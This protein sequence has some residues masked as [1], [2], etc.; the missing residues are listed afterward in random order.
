MP[1]SSLLIFLKVSFSQE[2]GDF[3]KTLA[4]DNGFTI[5]NGY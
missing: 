5:Y 1:H 3:D 4:E 2:L